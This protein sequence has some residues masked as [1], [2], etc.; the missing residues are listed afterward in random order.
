MC[1]SD[2]GGRLSMVLGF[3]WRDGRLRSHNETRGR[4]GNEVGADALGLHAR[5]EGE[6]SAETVRNE[7][8]FTG[9]G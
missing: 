5:V 1:F 6:K 2:L 3:T 9:E 8:L 7:T 4:S